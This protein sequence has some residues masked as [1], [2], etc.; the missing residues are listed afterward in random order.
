MMDKFSSTRRNFPPAVVRTASC[1][2]KKTS[3]LAPSLSEMGFDRVYPVYYEISFEK[4]QYG[5]QIRI[6]FI[7]KFNG[8]T[9]ISVHVVYHC[10]FICTSWLGW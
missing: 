8:N 2:N 1:N 6:I 3:R 5:A 4:I 7:K 9:G 10:S